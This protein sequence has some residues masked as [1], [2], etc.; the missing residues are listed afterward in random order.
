M[1]V[2]VKYFSFGTGLHQENA[3]ILQAPGAPREIL[4]LIRTKNSRLVA[5]HDYETIENTGTGSSADGTGSLTNL[6]LYDIAEYGPG[7]VGFGRADESG[8]RSHTHDSTQEIFELVERPTGNWRRPPGAEIGQGTQA[9]LLGRVGR[10]IESVEFCDIAADDGIVCTVHQNPITVGG[11][12]TVGIH[13][14]VAETDKTIATFG[15]SDAEKPRVVVVDGTFFIAYVV[16]S[17]GAIALQSFDP[18]TANDLT[19]LTSPV[20]AGNTVRAWD[21]TVSESSSTFWIAVARTGS[22]TAIRGLNSAGTVTYTAAGPAVLG[23]A[24]SIANKTFSG[25]E[26]THVTI[27]INST[28]ALDLYTYLPP[29]TTPSV[30][31]TDVLGATGVLTQAGIA[32]DMDNASSNFTLVYN[33]DFGAPDLNQC[34]YDRRSSTTHSVQSSG[35]IREFFVNSKPLVVNNRIVHSALVTEEVGFFTHA[36]ARIDDKSSEGNTRPVCVFDR[37]LA[38]RLDENHLPNVGYD[39][40]NDLV[41]FIVS[42]EGEDRQGSLQVLEIKIASTERRQTVQL[43]DV[44][45]IAGSIVQSYDGRE[46]AEAGGFLTRPYISSLLPGGAGDLDPAGI[47]QAIA[48]CEHRDSRGRRILSAPSNIQEATPSPDTNLTAAVTPSFS[49]RTRGAS[50]PVTPDQFQSSPLMSIYRTLDTNGGNGT[51]HLDEHTVIGFISGRTAVAYFLSQADDEISDDEIIYTQGARGALSGPLEFVCPD[52]CVSISASADRIM[53][54]G[55]IDQTRMQESRPLLVG[56][57]V[58]W[59]DT[60]GFYRDI[61]DRAL[62]GV[63][64][65][66]RRIIFA[67]DSIF[68]CDGP[69]LDDNGIGDIGP[70]RRLPSDVGLYG[71]RLG[72][73]SI[74]EVSAGVIFQGLRTQLYL[75]PRGGVTPSPIG[76][77]VEDKLDEYPVI[78][79]AVYMPEDQTVRFCCENEDGDESIILLLNLR[80]MEWFVEGPY[81][82]GIRSAAKASGRFYLLTGDNTLLRQRA[83]LEPLTFIEPAWRS[84]VIHPF[85]PGMYGRVYAF[86]YFGTF[87]GNCRIRAIAYWLDERQ[88]ETHDWVDVVDLEDGE[89]FSFRFEFDRLKCESCMVDFEVTSF[90][91]EATRGLEWNYAAIEQEASGVPLQVG[92]ENRS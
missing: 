23:D 51:F 37:F 49:M 88:S 36:I 86:W 19:T 84:G 8:M 43:G 44:L 67:A 76:F 22:T 38:H 42:T 40:T 31:S 30:S 62:S 20:A 66:E 56:E 74:V 78:K 79:A 1:T 46:A 65:D 53:T 82:F 64:L 54:T 60:I 63:R 89:Q 5:C 29:S 45:Y 14:F 34:S 48:V 4:N 50:D 16:T 11:A 12:A 7:I 39:S 24:I 91:G 71:G 57:Q 27:R 47:Y 75:L 33:D 2:I 69:G 3:E 90:Q 87:R 81:A 52:P 35:A 61:M 80:F 25:T 41:Y 18:A 72:W 70:P 32:S 58:Q 28:N 92:P 10:Q 13:F 85:S 6:R 26:R 9:R 55:L 59:S 77:S 15:I 21:M 83:E 68:E 73:R 17:T